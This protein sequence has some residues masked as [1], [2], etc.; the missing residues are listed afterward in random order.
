[1]IARCPALASLV[2]PLAALA[3][4]ARPPPQ[5]APRSPAEQR[6]VDLTWPLSAD[7]PTFSG[8]PTY[9]AEV[10][11]TIQ[12][13]GYYLAN[14]TVN[15]HT[16]THVDAPAHFAAGGA[17]VDQ[18][19]ADQLVGPAAVVDVTPAVAA[20]PDYAVTAADLRAWEAKHGPLGPRMI[21]LIR[22]GWGE[23]W[24]EPARYRNAD[25]KGVMHFP[26]VSP[27][28][29]RYLIDRGV[30]AIGIDT[31][32][33]D[34]GPSTT[35]AEHNQFLAA[36]GWHIENVAHL[37]QLPATGATLVV[38]PLPFRGGSGAPARVFAFLPPR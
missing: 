16:G 23:R 5:A 31:L 13:N 34:P 27:E 15:E 17:T 33:L 30:R 32:S 26:G 14:V 28:A 4:G 10:L 29:S 6:V 3:C 8:E 19:P 36:G 18:L 1:V 12:A 38:A 37:D 35:F 21:V 9:K 20:S 25:A 2:L 11:E 7:V 24:S 22:T